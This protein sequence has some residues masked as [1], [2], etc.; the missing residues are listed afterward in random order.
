MW[1]DAEGRV[2]SPRPAARAGRCPPGP[3]RTAHFFEGALS[4]TTPRARHSANRSFSVRRW[5]AVRG[6]ARVHVLGQE[7]LRLL[8]FFR[9]EE[10]IAQVERVDERVLDVGRGTPS[11]VR[12]GRAVS[13][14]TRRAGRRKF[15]RPLP[16]S[17]RP[18]VSGSTNVESMT[19]R[20]LRSIQDG[21]EDGQRLRGDG[22]VLQC[23]VP[24]CRRRRRNV[25]VVFRCPSR[26]PVRVALPARPAD[27]ALH[28]AP[29]RLV[30]QA[31]RCSTATTSAHCALPDMSSATA[32]F[33]CSTRQLMC[34]KPAVPRHAQ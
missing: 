33:A 10:A 7:R 31:T 12:A 3:C 24:D 17:S 15:R 23:A 26:L 19:R 25:F 16:G 28:L 34:T 20:D 32:S 21:L 18:R 13:P 29:D 5:C 2:P 4:Q 22:R 30:A 27:R 9:V 1:S 6:A 14:A 8:E 11:S